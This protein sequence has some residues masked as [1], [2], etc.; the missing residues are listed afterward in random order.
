MIMGGI[1]PL[2]SSWIK[3]HGSHILIDLGDNADA[4]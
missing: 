1:N 4:L 2:I 3:L